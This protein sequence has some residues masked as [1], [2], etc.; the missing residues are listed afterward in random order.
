M[1]YHPDAETA[2]SSQ[3]KM[4]PTS[5][6]SNLTLQKHPFQRDTHMSE[7]KQGGRN[8]VKPMNCFKFKAKERGTTQ[9]LVIKLQDPNKA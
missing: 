9:Y 1:V 4:K 7:P 8:L 3:K 5:K 2:R 6:F